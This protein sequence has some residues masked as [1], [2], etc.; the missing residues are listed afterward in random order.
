MEELNL[1]YNCINSLPGHWTLLQYLY[2]LHILETEMKNQP[3]NRR[4]NIEHIPIG[5]RQANQPHMRNQWK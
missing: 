1:N 4:W 3:L 2:E 5:I